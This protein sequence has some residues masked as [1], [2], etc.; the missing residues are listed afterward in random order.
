MKQKRY[1]S[2]QKL[3]RNSDGS[4]QTSSFHDYILVDFAVIDTPKFKRKFCHRFRMSYKSFQKHLEEL[5]KECPLFSSC[6]STTLNAAG[7]PPVPLELLLLGTL[8]YLGRGWMLN[9]LKETTCISKETHHRFLHVYIYCGSTFLYDKYV[10]LPES[11]EQIN[12]NSHK[13][14]IAGL[15][16]A[17]GSQDAT[18]MGMLVCHY[19][20]KQY[21]GSFKLPMPSRTYNITINQHRHILSSTRRHPER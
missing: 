6:S 18:H 7:R 14:F 10:L 16:G 17:I 2:S 20:L 1:Y 19:K 3:Y 9:N 15:A 21:H 5:V 8:Q 11:L 13:I 4:L 12:D